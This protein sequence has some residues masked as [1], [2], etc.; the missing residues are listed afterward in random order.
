M[1]II[2]KDQQY[3]IVTYYHWTIQ[4]DS[5]P[6]IDEQGREYCPF[7]YYQRPSEGNPVILG[8]NK[9]TA[10]VTPVRPGKPTPYITDDVEEITVARE[11]FCDKNYHYIHY[12]GK[13]NP[14]DPVENRFLSKHRRMNVPAPGWKE[15]MSRLA[16]IK[17]L[18]NAKRIALSNSSEGS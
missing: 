17:E 16:L 2:E 11:D 14:W 12:K 5:P 7:I 4:I 6:R 8:T 13:L 1:S 3:H 15:K 18:E 9:L 10:I